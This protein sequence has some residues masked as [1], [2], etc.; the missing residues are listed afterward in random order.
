MRRRFAAFPLIIALCAPV[1][2]FGQNAQ[3]AAPQRCADCRALAV[4]TKANGVA[5]ASMGAVK[6]A[7]ALAYK[8]YQGPRT[9]PPAIARR[10]ALLAIM[11]GRD[12]RQGRD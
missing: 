1:A 7:S 8:P 12:P 2:A 9:V 10:A 3:V 4:T 6:K 5:T 11:M